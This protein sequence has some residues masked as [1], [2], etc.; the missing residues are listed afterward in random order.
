M[1]QTGETISTWQGHSDPVRSVSF[2]PDGRRVVSGG[3]DQ[4][5][6]LW[7]VQTGEAIGEP[8]QKHSGSVSDVTFS[9]DGKQV[10]SGSSGYPN[11]PWDYAI[12]IWDVDENSWKKRLC[13]IAG[14]N[15]T[16]TEWQ[17]HLG[18]KPY[19]KT[20]SSYPKGQ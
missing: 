8:W 18:D 10:V 20:C 6:R 1:P 4:T 9:P 19:K 7:D 11:S 17:K 14:R 5:V 13:R 12:I 2:S 3:D 15:L 16:K